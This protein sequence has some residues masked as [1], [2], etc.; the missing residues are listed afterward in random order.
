MK[1]QWQEKKLGEVCDFQRGLTYSKNDEA[2]FSKNIVLRAN[3]VNIDNTLNLSELKYIKNEIVIPDNKKVKRGSMIICTANGSKR[4]L[5]KIA[6]IEQDYNYAFG[7]FMGQITPKNLDSKYLFYFLISDSYKNLIKNLSDGANINNL[8]FSDL[9]TFKIPVPPL[10]E[11]KRLVK[12]LDAIFAQIA[13]AKMTAEKNLCN[14]KELFAGYLQQIFANSREDWQEKNLGEVC[15][16]S[17]GKRNANHARANG[18][19]RFYTCAAKHV[20]CNTKRFSGECLV[21]PGNGVNVGKVFYYHG[22][23]D[24]YQRTYV[25]HEL[26][27]IPMF[28]YYHLCLFWKGRNINKQFGA[29]TNFIKMENFIE[30]KIPIPPL[31]E[32]KRL[33]KK[34]DTL[35]T[36]TKKLEDNYLGILKNLAELKKSILQLAFNGA[37]T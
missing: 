33:V 6:R 11:Q 1:T 9:K 22:D 4:H 37:L 20:F 12:K 14:A 27:I 32:Q 2:K 30:Y 24:V 36:K 25:L 26:K 15:D 13:Q 29:A 17:T 23:F 18:K 16:I 31:A 8:K 28:L 5:G 21:L 34:I 3:N 35:S 19:Y 10:A 7:G